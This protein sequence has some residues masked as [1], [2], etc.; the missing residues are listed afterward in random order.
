MRLGGGFRCRCSG[1]KILSLDIEASQGLPLTMKATE[2]LFHY[3]TT[4]AFHSIVQSRSIRLSSM[5][6]S[7]D[8]QE[9]RLASQ[10]V[11]RL[12]VRDGLTV[13]QR[14]SIAKDLAAYERTV[15]GL[16]F[17]LSEHGDLLSQWRGYSGDATGLS[18]GF[19]TERLFGLVDIH[20][21]DVTQEEPADDGFFID[22]HRVR[23]SDE[24]HEDEVQ[25]IYEQARYFASKE[26]NNIESAQ[27][28]LPRQLRNRGVGEPESFGVALL[29]MFYKLFLLKSKAFQAEDE[30]RL[31]S[32]SLRGVSDRSEF[33]QTERKLVPFRTV[34]ISRLQGAITSV[35][36]GPKHE[37]PV[38]V[39]QKFLGHCGFGEVT[40]TKSLI[41][42]R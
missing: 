25:P 21:R 27:P 11:D 32:Y 4:E 37:T 33:R 30:W 1:D 15:D 26:A 42:Y 41:S 7:N 14:N 3:C 34:D 8:A 22:L 31:I 5:S 10:A 9:G 23:Y 35:T 19:S 39:L 16:A 18:I 36:A 29:F 2:T 13:E 17:C 40:V 38:H 28:E 6:L 24:D 12:A 20:R